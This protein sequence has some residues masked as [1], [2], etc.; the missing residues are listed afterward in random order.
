MALSEFIDFRRPRWRSFAY[1]T[2]P[3]I[4]IWTAFA[5]LAQALWLLGPRTSWGPS[6]VG[7]ALPLLLPAARLASGKRWRS[8]VCAALSFCLPACTLRLL[9][10]LLTFGTGDMPE[11]PRLKQCLLLEAVAEFLRE[12]AITTGLGL[13]VLL[14]CFRTRAPSAERRDFLVATGVS[15]LATLCATAL[16]AGV[17]GALRE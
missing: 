5:W 12:N 17:L 8:A 11:D 10:E 2:A 6:L 1:K 14:C 4:L 13:F 15:L 9:C 7:F 16:G 3:T